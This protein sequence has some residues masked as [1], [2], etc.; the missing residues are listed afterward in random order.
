MTQ[1]D[2]EFSFLKK[3]N[4]LIGYAGDPFDQRRGCEIEPCSTG[5]CGTNAEC[6]SNGRTAICK[7]ILL[8]CNRI[9]NS[10]SIQQS[11]TGHFVNLHDFYL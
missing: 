6:E 7:V 9:E 5:P 11:D 2:D 3:F 8:S 1:I 4:N 10:I